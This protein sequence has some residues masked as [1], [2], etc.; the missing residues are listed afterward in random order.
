MGGD[1]KDLEAIRFAAVCYEP[2]GQSLVLSR[3]KDVRC[4]GRTVEAIFRMRP[5]S[6]K[7]LDRTDREPVGVRPH[8]PVVPERMAA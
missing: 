5:G 1:E 3:G 6:V 2:Q 7:L 8:V 4:A